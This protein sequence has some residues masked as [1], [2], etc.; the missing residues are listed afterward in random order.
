MTWPL[1]I[2]QYLRNFAG[3]FPGHIF[4]TRPLA[5]CQ[6]LRNLAGMSPGYKSN[7]AIELHKAKCWN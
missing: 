4:T 3:M 1:A 7:Q 6:Y 2:C 5:I